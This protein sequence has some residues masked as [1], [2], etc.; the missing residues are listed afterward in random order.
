VVLCPDRFGFE[1]RNL[2]NS[3]YAETFARF[4][5]FGEDG[6]ELTEDLFMGC[7]AN[8]LIFEGRTPLGQTL[9]ELQRAVDCLCAQPEVDPARIGVIGHSAGGLYA[10]LAMY[11]D[12]R[13]AAGCASCGTF[14]FRWIWGPGGVPRPINGFGGA[15]VPGMARWG[16]VDDVLAGLAP[17]P[18]LETRG[19]GLY[20]TPEQLAELTGKARERYSSLGAADRYE[21]V[22]YHAGH[23][24]RADMRERSYAWLDQ[25]LKR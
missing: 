23:M 8:R 25:W 22:T 19:D 15:T 12:D 2:A 6:L 21:Y 9:F 1:S 11:L 24:F 14:L 5:I 16:D 20:F 17:R 4:R 7:F 18:F 10:V 3:P 13:I